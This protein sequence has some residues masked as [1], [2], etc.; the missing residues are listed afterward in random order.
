MNFDDDP[1]ARR[2]EGERQVPSAA[3]RGQLRS[4][5]T[6]RVPPARPPRLRLLIVAYG[7]AGVALL[8]AAALS[9]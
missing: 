5:L 4:R 2:L 3:W 8:G 6:A 1:I 9:I 7:G